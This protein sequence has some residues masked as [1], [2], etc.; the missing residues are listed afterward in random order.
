MR[1]FI[2]I[3]FNNEIKSDLLSNI[4]K[5]QEASIK[6]N[7]TCDENLHLTLAFIGETD[8][9]N[10][11]KKVIDEIKAV[12]FL[13]TL[14]KNGVFKRSGGDIHWVGIERSDELLA[15]KNQISNNLR[16]QG[17]FQENKDFLPHITLSRETI[18]KSNI[19]FKIQK[20]S[21]KVTIISLMK[22]EHIKGKLVYTEIYRK[23]L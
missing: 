8:R 16:S 11:I 15:V 17:F 12:P 18:L 9:L 2:A 1:L 7:F 4:K 10:G 20:L 6:G 19:E 3:I 13:I 14:G 23:Q 22:S 21:M 5:L